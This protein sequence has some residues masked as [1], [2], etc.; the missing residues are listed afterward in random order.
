MKICFLTIEFPHEKTGT[1]GGIGTSIF[2]LSKGLVQLGHQVIIIIYAQDRDQ[3]FAENGIT[4]YKV[5]NIKR[6]GFSLYLTQKK[7]EGL[8]NSLYKK[9]LIDIVEVP[10]WTGI[11]SF[12]KPKCP[13]VIKLHGSDTYF[14]HLDERPVKWINKFLEK[15]ALKKANGIIA[16]SQFTGDLTN[17]LFN[18]KKDF[19]VIHNSVDIS[20]FKKI[21]NENDDFTILYFGTL[22]RKKGLLELPLIFNEVYAK[23]SNAKLILIGTNALDINE[24]WTPTWDL[25]QPLFNEDALQNVSYLGSVPH[26]EIKNKIDTATVCVFPTFAEALPVSWLEAMAMQKAVVASNIGWATEIIEN[27]KNGFLV[28]PKDH[29]LY[30][31]KIL[32]LFN[33]KV[34]TMQFG[35]ESRK[36]MIENFNVKIIAQQSIDY[37]SKFIKLQ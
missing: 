29:Q 16:V 34:L 15:R 31:S 13:L 20:Q 10:D 7:V 26:S 27:G 25:M 24:N 23:N 37:Y 11:S 14:C 2:N 8:I 12:I 1:S 17:T 33:N 35:I 5:K 19:T 4:Y 22:I 9:K 3:I 36:N 6:K 32:E 28:F 18:L 21:S 30:A